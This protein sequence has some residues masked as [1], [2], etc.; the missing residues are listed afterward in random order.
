MIDSPS[1]ACSNT[2]HSKYFKPG[3]YE[4]CLAPSRLFDPL[5]FVR[6][7]SLIFGAILTNV[8][9]SEPTSMQIEPTP[10]KMK[11]SLGSM[12]AFWKTTGA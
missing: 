11:D 9:S 1:D 10:P 7:A 8:G 4:E 2:T 6:Y 12:P 3:T 5:E